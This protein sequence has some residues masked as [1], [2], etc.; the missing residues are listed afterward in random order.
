[1]CVNLMNETFLT[2]AL[3]ID[4]L[5]AYIDIYT[6][7]VRYLKPSNTAVLSPGPTPPDQVNKSISLQVS[8]I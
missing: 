4:T 1:M 3:S 6:N 2:E 7:L 8:F 5:E